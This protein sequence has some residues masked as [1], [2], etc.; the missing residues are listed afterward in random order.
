MHCLS[1]I[2]NGHLEVIQVENIEGT[3]QNQKL[4]EILENA[5]YETKLCVHATVSR[6]R[7]MTGKGF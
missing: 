7:K 6:S 3:L 1:R 2:V 4:K 5:E